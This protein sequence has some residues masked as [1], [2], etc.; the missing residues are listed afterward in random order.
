MTQ[1]EYIIRRK[2]IKL[3]LV[4]NISEACRKLSVSR[5]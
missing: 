2:V 5:Q 4:R 3:K 1:Q